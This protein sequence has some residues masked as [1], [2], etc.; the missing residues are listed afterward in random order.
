MIMDHVLQDIHIF[1]A[2][3]L[4]DIVVHMEEHLICLHIFMERLRKAGLKI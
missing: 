4:D 3:Y 1:I 2:A